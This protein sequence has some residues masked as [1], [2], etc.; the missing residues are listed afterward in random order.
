MAVPPDPLP[1]T[2][3][4][5]AIGAMA[6]GRRPAAGAPPCVGPASRGVRPHRRGAR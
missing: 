6:S 2:V 1:T 5:L 4:L 3:T